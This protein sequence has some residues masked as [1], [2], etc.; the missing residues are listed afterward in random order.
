MYFG[1][2]PSSLC[3]NIALSFPFP[4]EPKQG[5][6]ERNPAPAEPLPGL[7]ASGA[8]L[9]DPLHL[10]RGSSRSIRIKYSVEEQKK[11]M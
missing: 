5:A 6:A 7:S 2:A 3:I 10:S 8:A 1:C 9:P 11:T 4:S